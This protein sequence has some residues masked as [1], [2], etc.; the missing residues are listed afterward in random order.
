MP[1]LRTT[2]SG[3]VP[4]AGDGSYNGPPNDGRT[5]T[6][7]DGE[8]ADD[9]I[10]GL[11]K[12]E[13][14]ATILKRDEPDDPAAVRGAL[15]QVT[16]D[17]LVCW[18]AAD[19]A[20]AHASKVVSTPETRVEFASMA[21]ED[22]KE[23]ASPVSHL[24]VVRARVT[25]LEARLSTLES[26]V[27]E[28][29]E[30][31]RAVVERCE[32][33]GDL[34]AVARGLRDVTAEADRLHGAIEDL[35]LDAE[36]FETWL[37]SHD[38]RIQEFGEDVDAVVGSLDELADAVDR[39]E[40]SVGAVGG[41]EAPEVDRNAEPSAAWY[42]ANR[43]LRVVDLLVAD[44]QAELDALRALA[45]REDAEPSDRTDE[46]EARLGDLDARVASIAD[47]LKAVAEP[48]W[49]EQ[50]GDRLAAFE[51][52]I[53]EFEPPVDWGELQ[54]TLESHRTDVDDAGS[55]ASERAE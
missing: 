49:R 23:A 27:A 50:Y 34:Y 36:A 28:V 6:L 18:D 32:E 14:V 52:A 38:V 47:R 19:E 5:V 43:R 9:S 41:T 54:A 40:D 22:A 11:P 51:S 55:T 15:D 7:E 20:L 24:D 30:M 46:V 48:A 39:L 25:D 1:P 16:A 33:R 45:D 53:D 21:L 2:H 44:L 42:D 13:A 3:T 8:T 29:A 37:G 35:R 17:G 31:L 4:Q 12:E 26:E 10:A